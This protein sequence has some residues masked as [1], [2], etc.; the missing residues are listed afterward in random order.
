MYRLSRAVLPGMIERGMGFI[1]NI[2]SIAGLMGMEARF[3]YTTTKHAV[4]GMTRAMAMDHGTTG[5]RIN[6]ICPGRVR[7]PFVVT[8]CDSIRIPT[9]ISARWRLRTP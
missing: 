2:A 8:C 6:C 5:V 4:V 1:V 3:A 7:T 9:T